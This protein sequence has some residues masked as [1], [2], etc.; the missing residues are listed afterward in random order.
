MDI[1]IIPFSAL[2]TSS[3]KGLLLQA[4]IALKDRNDSAENSEFLRQIISGEDLLKE[5]AD[6]ET[7]QQSNMLWSG[8]LNL[9]SIYDNRVSA[10]SLKPLMIQDWTE[11]ITN[12]ADSV[13]ERY[14]FSS[15][16]RVCKNPAV[17]D[18]PLSRFSL[19]ESETELSI[20]KVTDRI[21]EGF[22]TEPDIKIS[23]GQLN[24]KIN[25]LF[26]KNQSHDFLKH[27]L[28]PVNSIK[29][30]LNYHGHNL[31]KDD[32]V[33]N[34]FRSGSYPG[35]IESDSMA[36]FLSPAFIEHASGQPNREIIRLGQDLNLRIKR[37]KNQFQ[38]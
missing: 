10:G 2:E 25:L 5:E 38:S 14:S 21:P 11:S 31:I 20:N 17:P 24:A 37:S 7:C 29:S 27:I 1:M 12:P 9:F 3:F 32:S 34:S 19:K 13:S 15:Q 4:S 35:D 23:E 30:S 26:N 16:E 22:H 8:I 36:G 28:S 6:K 18:L 33:V